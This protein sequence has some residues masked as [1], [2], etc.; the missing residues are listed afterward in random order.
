MSDELKEEVR[1]IFLERKS[2]ISHDD[3]CIYINC[4]ELA[5]PYII[6]RNECD[7]YEKLA[8]WTQH[9]LEKTWMTNERVR[10]FQAKAAELFH[11]GTRIVL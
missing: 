2:L 6:R 7:S 11:P 8:V 3:Q 1:A 9:L 5:H 4:Q 10:I